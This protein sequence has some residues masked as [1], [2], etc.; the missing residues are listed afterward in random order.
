MPRKSSSKLSSAKAF[1]LGEASVRL[2]GF[3]PKD[4]PA[5][6]GLRSRVIA[7]EIDVDEMVDQ[8]LALH[9]HA[10]SKTFAA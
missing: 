2:E 9:N 1:R 3:E 6:E 4:E 10:S 5:Y 7:G 8:L